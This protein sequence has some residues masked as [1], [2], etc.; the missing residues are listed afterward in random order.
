[1][2]YTIKITDD[3]TT[4]AQKLVS[5]LKSLAK[6]YSFLQITEEKDEILTEEMMKDL[7]ARYEH[8]LKHSTEYKNWNVIKKGYLKK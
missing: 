2:T 8:F 3:K 4:Q 7:D 6:D 1:M 5:F